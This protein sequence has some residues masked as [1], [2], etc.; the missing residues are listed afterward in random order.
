MPVSRRR[1]LGTSA[2]VGAAVVVGELPAVATAAPRTSIPQRLNS[3]PPA[4]PM[5]ALNRMAY[6]PR[7]GDVE[8]VKALGLDA[9]VEE[10]LAPANIDDSDCDRRLGA[11]N[12]QTL[13]LSRTELWTQYHKLPNW[14]DRLL[15]FREVRDATWIRAVYSKRQLQE[16]LLEFWHNH[17]NVHATS[18]SDIACTWPD[19][20][21]SLR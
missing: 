14:N 20:D 1:F 16:V 18:N 11:R 7:P 10:Q 5:I 13:N 9:Y 4:G 8:R 3:T 6:G 19:Y 2:A 12:Y 17:F 15:P 21:R